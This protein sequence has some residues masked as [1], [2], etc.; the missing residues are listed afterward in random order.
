MHGRFPSQLLHKYPRMSKED[1]EIWVKF[2]KLHATAF[3]SFNY[4]LPV[5]EGVDPGEDVP[6][7]YRKDF[8]DLTRKRID[9]VGYT[10]DHVTIFEVKPRAGTTALGQLLT[11]RPL[12]MQSYPEFSDVNSAV[13]TT[14]MNDEEKT[15]YQNYN[16]KIY[17]VQ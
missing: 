16:I 14:F 17:I 8:V 5:G 2:L 12:F 1:T 3:D 11:Y 4:D 10:G 9:A 13:V 15:I 7:I 6:A